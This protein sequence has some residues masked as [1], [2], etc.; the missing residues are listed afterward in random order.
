ME[1]TGNAQ[2]R[3]EKCEEDVP[4][5]SPFDFVIKQFKGKKSS[6]G[7]RKEQPS[8]ARK[9]FGGLDF[10]KSEV[11]DRRETEET[12]I[13]RADDQNEKEDLSTQD[14]PSHLISEAESP[15]GKQRFNQFMQKLGKKPNSKN[16]DLNN[17]AL[18]ETDVT[19]LASLLP[20]L[21]ELEEISL[22]W[23]GGVGGSLKALTV[24]LHHVN[25][26]KVLRLN[27]CRLTAEDVTSLGEAFEI[28]PQLEELDL[29]WNSNIGGKLSLL[30][31]KLQKGCKIKFLKITDC[32]LTAKDGE[33]LA[34]ILNVIP[35]LEVLDLSVNKHIGCSMKIIAQDLKNVPGLKELNLHM[36]GL[37]QDSLQGLD[38]ALQHLAELRKLDVSCNREIGGGFKDSTAHLAS[39]KN[40][41][42]L[43]L[44]QCCVTEED[45]TVLS[46]VI[47]LLSSLQELNLSSNKNIG[48]SSEP[49]LSRLRFLP[50]LKSVAISNCCLREE[51]FS[52]LVLLTQDGH[53]ARLQK[54]DLSY[55]DNICDEGWAVFCKGLAVFK[56][57]S[58]LDVSLRP[59][60]CR[61]CGMWFSELLAALTKL[62]ALAELGM[63]RWVLSESQ[64]KQLESFNQD[65]K[66]S[67]RF[68]C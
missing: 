52:S 16:L 40:L 53:L 10:V 41:E 65:N 23:N 44:H 25:L 35:N 56:E 64:R 67:I 58:E 4:K 24:Q 43:D 34:Q 33:S 27:N 66:R 50:K 22:S 48:V 29:S 21:P 59:S 57:L 46:Q 36:C 39:L 55:N 14:G 45:M 9:V 32:N 61:D 49:L 31:K 6:P 19:E 63:Q 28:V 54:L 18:S 12:E 2:S 5:S 8:A 68:D 20:F 7:K 38:T 3:Q 42:V 60:S 17:C 37:K 26:L 51:S 13:N 11:K 15:S 47:P 30:T 62:P 1:K